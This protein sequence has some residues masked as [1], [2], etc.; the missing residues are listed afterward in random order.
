MKT[1]VI[2]TNEEFKEREFK[3]PPYQAIAYDKNGRMVQTFT[4]EG[5]SKVAYWSVRELTK[6]K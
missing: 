4:K 2:M 1:V 5:S 3:N 6:N